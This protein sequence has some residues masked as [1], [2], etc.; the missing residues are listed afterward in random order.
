M[1]RPG[2]QAEIPLARAE[3]KADGMRRVSDYERFNPQRVSTFLD[4]F[5]DLTFKATRE[6]RAE[7]L[8]RRI[9]QAELT[10]AEKIE[11]F[12]RL[13]PSGTWTPGRDELRMERLLCSVD[14]QDLALF[15]Y[16]LEYDG[17]YKDLEE[18][19]CHDIDDEGCRNRVVAHLRSAPSD[20]GVKVLSDVDDTM[21]PNLIDERYP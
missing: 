19:L 14:T 4:A 10:L 21:Y 5:D 17:D 2:N 15:K 16:A 13:A 8:D 3:H 11:A 6:K 1:L 20:N 7:E 9:S 18:Y 12:R